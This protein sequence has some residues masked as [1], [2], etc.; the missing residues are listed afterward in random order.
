MLGYGIVSAKDKSGQE[1]PGTLAW[2]LKEPSKAPLIKHLFDGQGKPVVWHNVWM[3]NTHNW[4]KETSRGP[5]SLGCGSNKDNF[6]PEL[7]FGIV[8]GEFYKNQVLIIKTAWGGK[9][10]YKD[11][12]PPSSGGTVG[13]TYLQMIAAVKGVLAN[14]KQEFPG[15]DGGGYA[16]SGFVWWHGWNDHIDACNHEYERGPAEYE[17]NLLN[18]VRDV[19]QRPGDAELARRDRRVPRQLRER[20]HGY[21]CSR[22]HDSQGPGRR[23]GAPEFKGSVVFVPTHDFGIPKEQSPGPWEPHHEYRSAETYYLVGAAFG[24]AMKTL[25]VA[26]KRP[27]NYQHAPMKRKLPWRR[28]GQAHLPGP[29]LCRH[30]RGR[31]ADWQPRDLRCDGPARVYE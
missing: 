28:P 7:G 27:I 12:R 31:R 25:L 14:L 18:L 13:P 21:S 19:P 22:G 23:G 17:E 10:L 29:G 30:R 24:K 9:S 16:L 8:M 3:D 5:L 15:Y 11:F 26:G 2:M 20:L 6:G 4:P 1:L